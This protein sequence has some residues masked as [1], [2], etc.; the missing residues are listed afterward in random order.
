MVGLLLGF[1]SMTG[2]GLGW[3]RALRL[4]G[5]PSRWSQALTWYFVGQLGKYLPGG[6]W[7][8]VGRGELAARSGAPRA[9]TYAAV[10][11]SLGAT[12]MAAILTVLVLL[13]LEPA[14]ARER[15]QTLWI[16]LLLPLG[17]GAAHP[18][19]LKWALALAGRTKRG[20]EELEIPAWGATA[21]L[22]LLHVPSWVG[23][24]CATW[25]VTNA[26]QPG[27]PFLDV[28]PAMVVAWV[29]GFLAVPVPGGIGVREA[30]FA[31]TASSLPGGMAAAVAVVCRFLFMVVDALGA[32]LAVLV[33]SLGA[34]GT[35]TASPG[36][37]PSAPPSDS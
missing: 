2:I 10:F 11:L 36:G 25:A 7:P 20:G 35:S 9:R 8:I 33:S 16:L 29:A 3:K 27:V 17:F 19:V 6:I 26:L 14:P 5:V 28:A 18:V 30:V 23:I 34:S 12:Y 21:A 24:G 4:L 1:L 13:A 37:P 32:G 31:L 15:P 22:V